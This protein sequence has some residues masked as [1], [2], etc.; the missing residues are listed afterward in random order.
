MKGAEKLAEGKSPLTAA[1]SA[2]KEKVTEKV[3]GMFH[4]GSGSGG[5]KTVNITETIDVGVPRS[6]A[7]NQWTQFQEFTSFSKGIQTVDQ[8]EDTQLNWRAKIA[9]SSRSWESTIQ[10]QIPDYKIVWTSK[11]AKGSVDGVVTFHEVT[12]D[13]TRVIMQL[14]YHPQGLF[15]KTGNL[16]RAQG[17]RARLDLKGFSRFVMLQGEE[18]G[19]WRGEIHD[20]QVTKSPEEAEQEEQQGDEDEQKSE[21]RDQD[22]Q[23]SEGGDQ[24]KQKSEGRD[25]DKQKSEG[26]DQDKQKSQNRGQGKRQ[27]GSGD[28]DKQASNG[29]G[30]S[31]QRSQGGQ[32]QDKQGSNGRGQA[33][34]G[35]GSSGSQRPRKAP[36][37]QRATAGSRG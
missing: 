1:A 35:Q 2:A 8:A 17:R 24:D 18:S 30:Q 14:V 20:G 21:G 36:S 6:T 10:E 25:Q 15:E 22:K 16:W 27:S 28:E 29:R 32:D 31:R 11:G 12:P 3:K 7:Y 13:L 26:G 5:K 37:R 4:K 33:K 19:S 23:K 34:Q 9:F